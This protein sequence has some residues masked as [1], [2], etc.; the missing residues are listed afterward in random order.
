MENYINNKIQKISMGLQEVIKILKKMKLKVREPVT[1]LTFKRNLGTMNKIT[2]IIKRNENPLNMIV[3]GEM[4]ITVILDPE[5]ATAV[6]RELKKD[7]IKK[8]DNASQFILAMPEEAQ[9]T[10]GII[11]HLTK[12]LAEKE[13]N[14][15]D[16]FAC[17][18]DIVIV[19]ST[20]DREETVKTLNR[21]TP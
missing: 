19:V 6:E 17:Y 15:I 14:I 16:M 8:T 9:K 1:E 5:N 4:G 2:D 20:H 12:T 18:S 21:I 7:F 10:P 3:T 13:I 11:Y